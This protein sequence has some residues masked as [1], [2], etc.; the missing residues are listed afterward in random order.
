MDPKR[1]TL[2]V[3]IYNEEES[4]RDFAPAIADFSRQHGFGLIFVNDGST[5]GSAGI[6]KKS[7]LNYISHQA[8]YGYGAALKTGVKRATREFV[9]FVD[10]DGQHR[11]EDVLKVAQ[12]ADEK[13]MTIG[14]RKNLYR[15]TL[16]AML[17]RFILTGMVN[18][19]TQSNVKD[20]NSGLRLVQRK[21]FLRYE[22][23]LPDNFSCTTTLTILAIKFRHGIRFV[24]IEIMKRKGKSKVNLLR[25][26][27][28]LIVLILRAMTLAD[29]LAIFLPMSLFFMF[30]SVIYGFYI[31]IR[32]GLGI[33]VGALILFI[34]SIILF[35]LG[36]ICDQISALRLTILRRCQD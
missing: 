14:E 20:I 22:P 30:S 21:I 33:P 11:L 19:L 24:P 31:A 4:L 34:T 5:D 18:M 16:C 36:I 25:D 13:E 32:D 9:M 12:T 35:A 6:L 26:G 23:V 1:I 7:S 10:S 15:L 17:G 8:R 29:P 3:P 27:L 2:I 28:N